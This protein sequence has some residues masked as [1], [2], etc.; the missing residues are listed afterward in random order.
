MEPAC[1][2][3]WLRRPMSS[4]HQR[5]LLGG[6]LQTH[7]VR[8]G[9]IDH[10][11]LFGLTQSWRAL[12]GSEYSPPR[13]RTPLIELF[14][15]ILHAT[16]ALAFRPLHNKTGG[17]VLARTRRKRECD[18]RRDAPPQ[19][20]DVERHF[21]IVARRVR[22]G[23]NDMGVIDELF[24][25]RRIKTRKAHMKIDLDRETGRDRANANI[26]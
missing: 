6:R 9:L 7:H 14:K 16:P 21:H 26:G 10:F 12:R 15:N 4:R 20:L 25:R 2:R 19:D 3:P 22:I 5:H 8:D 24:D 17:P 13:F 11:D 18:E 1:S 23:A